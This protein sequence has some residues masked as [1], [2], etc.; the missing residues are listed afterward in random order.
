MFFLRFRLGEA[1]GSPQK[2]HGRGNYGFAAFS[3]RF[4]CVFLRFR[5]GEARGSPQKARGRGNDGFAAFS[6]R[7][8]YVLKA[9]AATLPEAR[10]WP[11]LNPTVFLLV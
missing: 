7:F 11:S 1:R 9:F 8:Q 3:I 6:I 4:Q 5:L 10:D 2:A